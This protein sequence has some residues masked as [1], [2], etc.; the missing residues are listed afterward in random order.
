M[1]STRHGVRIEARSA[2]VAL[3]E[4]EPEL[5]VIDAAIARA[6]EGSGGTLAI[7]GPAGIGKT[8]LLHAARERVEEADLL[9]LGAAGR[10]LEERFA[11]GVAR[12]LFEPALRALEPAVRERVL[13][14][15]A[16]PAASL[17]GD[18]TETVAPPDAAF[19]LAHALY[20]LT[21]NLAELHPLVLVVDDLQWA[22]RPSRQTLGYLAPRLGEH[23]VL[24]AIA[25]RSGEVELDPFSPK[26]APAEIILPAPL[27]TIAVRHVVRAAV[28]PNASDEFCEACH[29]AT[30]GNP[31]LARELA[32]A[33][34]D[35]GLAGAASDLDA[36]GAIAPES[37]SRSAL[38]RLRR[39]GEDPRALARALAVL[40][41]AGIQLT[42]ALAH[43][44][45][46]D[47]VDAAEALADADILSGELPLRFMHP[48]L[49][50][51]VYEDLSPA[52]RERAHREAAEHLAERGGDPR[53]IASHLERSE[54]RGET[55]AVEA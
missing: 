35:E 32:L 36:L 7:Q 30:G 3:L 15:G 13:S 11:F 33:A 6:R 26:D 29:R 52:A 23:P 45:E 43:L 34:A 25:V 44:D 39:L 20:W 41:R 12:Q 53:A 10:E 47:A 16:A 8:A 37:I 1:A 9:S 14:G 27:S 2:P 21:A 42:A 48:I 5:R 50:G 22:D 28:D 4:R 38:L 49:R 55:W 17:F 54:P 46:S 19:A 40:E 18:A 51:A 24:L 31:F